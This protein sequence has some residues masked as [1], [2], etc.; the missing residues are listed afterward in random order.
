[1]EVLSSYIKK[2]DH[3]LKEI[4][5]RSL[6][7]LIEKLKLGWQLEDE[8]SCTRKLL[9]CLLAW[10]Q[11]QKPTL[12]SEALCLLLK[13][14]KTKSGTYIVKEM[15][16]NKILNDLKEIKNK[17][18]TEALVLYDDVVDT[19]YFLKTVESENDLVP[20]LIFGSSTSSESAQGINGDN[21]NSPHHED[22]TNQQD[23]FSLKYDRKADSSTMSTTS[24]GINVLLFPWVDICP[25]DLKT[26]VLLEDALKVVKSIRRCC[27]FICDVFLKDF[28]PEIF[29]N[30]PTIVNILV[31]IADGQQTGHPREALYVLLCITQALHQRLEQLFSIELVHTKNKV[32]VEV[33]ESYDEVNAEL[34][35]IAGG[36]NLH[37][38]EDSLTPLRQIPAP[39]FALNTAHSVLSIMS[40]SIVLLDPNENEV[41][42][43]RE[44]NTC[45]DL[46]DSLIQLLLKCVSEQF[47]IAEH[48]YKTH[49]DI[50]HKTCMLM[51]ML[52]DLLIKYRKS[53]MENTDRDHHRLAWLR[54]M[55]I[56]EKLLDWAKSSPIPPSSMIV[57]L[58]AAQLDPV[59]ELLYPD[60]S[61]RINDSLSN[62]KSVLD[63]EHKNKYKA[64]KDL[65][66]SMDFAVKFM[67]NKK[68]DRNLKEVLIEIQNSI[69]I[70]GLQH[71][72]VF[73]EDICNILLVKT[74]NLSDDNDWSVVRNI[75][76]KLMSHNIEWVK[77]KFYQK[78]EVMVNSILFSNEVYQSNEQCL[79]LLCDVGIL[80]EICCHGL[81]SNLEQVRSSASE[82]M[83]YLLRGRLVL[84]E[85][86][87]WRVLASL[88]PIL[89]L[90][91]VYAAHD[92]PIGKAIC[93]S[94]EPDIVERMGVSFAEMVSGL[95][96]LLF[97]KCVVVQLE[98]A[99]SLCR[100]LDDDRYLPPRE[101]LRSDLLLNALRRVEPEEF[102][103][104]SSSSFTKSPQTAGLVQ[105]LEVLKQDLRWEGVG[106][107]YVALTSRPSLEPSLRRSTLQ[108]LAVLLRQ[109]DTHD[110]FL[111]H[112]GVNLIVSLLRLSLMVEDYLVFPECAI[113]CVSVLNSVCFTSRHNLV[114]ITDLP[115]LLLRVILVFPS[116]ESCVLMSAQTLSL[117][118]WSGFVLQDID[119]SRQKV[120]ALPYCV[121]ERTSLPYHVNSYWNTSPNAEH[122]TLEW[123]LSEDEWRRCVRIRWWCTWAGGV[124]AVRT[125]L[126]AL[127]PLPAPAPSP[128]DLALMRS[129]CVLHSSTKGLLALENATSHAQVLEA[130]ALLQS[131]TSLVSSSST[132]LME[133][134]SLPWQH[135]RRFL[136]APPAS[137]NDTALLTALLRFIV[138][139]MDNVPSS[140][141]TMGWIIS[142]FICN[143][144]AVISLLS[145]DRLYPQQTSQEDIEVI[146]LHIHIVKVIWRC[147][148][149]LDIQDDYDAKRMESLLKILLSCLEN[150]DIKNFHMQGYLN[151][152]MRCIRYALYSRYCHLSEDTL[153]EAL[154]ILTK[155]F[156]NC[157][158]GSGFKSQGCKLDALLAL[159]AI[160]RQIYEN[161]VPVQ[162]WS[163][164][165][166][167]GALQAAAACVRGERAALRAAALHV[168]AALAHYTQL[169][170]H[171]LQCISSESI[172]HYALE[173]LLRCGE[174]NIVRAAAASLLAAVTAR[175]T[176][177]S[178]VFEND[179]IQHIKEADFL[180]SCLQIFIDF[181][182]EKK[183][184]NY[185]QPNMPLS[186]LE[187][188][189]EL[190]VRACKSGELRLSPSEEFVQAPPSVDLVVAVADV[191]HNISAFKHCPVD[192]WNEQGVYRVMFRCASWSCG[193]LEQRH[194]VRAAVCRALAAAAT[195]KCVRASLANT[196]DCLVNL[197]LTL[198]MT[199]EGDNEEMSARTQTFSLLAVLLPERSAGDVVW[200]EL[201]D[202]Q[203]MPFF[204]I[205][206]HSLQTDD[207]EL[208]DAAMH[209]LTQ[210]IKSASN[211][212]NAD[213]SS[214]EYFIEF[215]SNMKCESVV[216]SARSG[217]GDSGRDDC[218]PDYLCEELCKLLIYIFQDIFD[219][220]KCGASQ[221]DAWV[222]VSS[223]LCVLVSWCARCRAYGAHRQLPRAL[224]AALRAT[225]DHLTMHGKPA[226]VIR[227]A[228]HEPVLNTLYW[229]LTLI[230]SLM[231]DCPAAKE[232]FADNITCSLNK[233][234]PWCM[235]TEQLR[236]A[237]MHLL[238]TFTNDCPKA[239]ACM[240]ACVGG[241]NLVGEVC[242]V[243]GRGGGP[244]LPALRTLRHCAAHHHCR[245]ILLKSEVLS[246]MSKTCG[247]GASWSAACVAWARL[248]TALAR[249]SDGGAAL[250]SLPALRPPHPR[251]L[252]ALAHTAHHH[253]ATFLHAPDLL[254][255][256]SA[257][258]LT[259][260]TS[261]VVLAARAA[262]ALAANNHRAKLV[263]RGAG[264]TSAVQSALQRHQRSTAEDAQ[265]ALQLL[266][267]T[268]NVLQAT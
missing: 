30:R 84:S 40:R 175:Y 58:Q 59:I 3:P 26:I 49:K 122:C 195:R 21:Y 50:A 216:Q 141:A 24:D 149:L 105:M 76:L 25:S 162:R 249:Y 13:T 167:G 146:Q 266:T 154:N 72:E 41:L 20:P 164:A 47:W 206:M 83:Q 4:R 257:A 5:E 227:N 128:H 152:V 113:S 203:A 213:K 127:P 79:M 101:S 242:R 199:E 99:H 22:L 7:L 2:L 256:L 263:L 34:E 201:T 87:W 262:W 140:R 43:M 28:P 145:R 53:F 52:G 245:A 185:L 33:K 208:R 229:L 260:N 176:P 14:I 161:D 233:L 192:L 57:A 248:C 223:C 125:A 60:L 110:I 37:G 18:D 157:G 187:R 158:V 70:L 103:L 200:T 97:V 184:Q 138:T 150:I 61:R 163:E 94:L 217:A 169:L 54:L 78:L 210:L 238:V 183:Y 46:I 225:R 1:M 71:S 237:I 19:L 194:R 66:T 112:D 102:N 147:V 132:S 240:C 104:D 244:L 109:H 75:A 228:N 224:L 268:Y 235:M 243:V 126:A 81:S 9:E 230:N 85:S 74:N 239:W 130:L 264:V 114:K 65:Y 29:L 177:H 180:E 215:F 31:M 119:S 63:Q 86:C 42:S 32:S 67:K 108:Q 214:D 120:P 39:I 118:A 117:V 197:L 131:H 124:R 255:F 93:K 259:G 107:S 88:L 253:R 189:S 218:Q 261:E 15:G 160:L 98:A 144:V 148:R 129:S 36:G 6:Q 258:L 211:K 219:K 251:L 96:R 106:K 155:T 209:C 156:S 222:R 182:D 134:G 27:R 232:A 186:V 115:L 45:L 166:C 168:M 204:T 12:Q 135:V 121:T 142:Y 205:L 159:M 190:E 170:P 111:Q 265:Q 221:E 80:T 69:P 173:I 95:T 91:H 73:L 48:S 153:I 181:C 196:K 193:S 172:C 151:E 220:R 246:F 139:Y 241:R 234:W 133:Y 62:C 179:I 89:P 68:I 92:T 77:V 250:L 64:L 38:A 171:L 136:C 90:L 198:T 226:D 16:I 11:V 212:K 137:A 207:D 143:D 8:L 56:A 191:L 44:L 82:I 254:E 252:P 247:R 174:A 55:S 23:L 236:T 100:L 116:N 178:T 17:V 51:R 165:W 202:R 267:Y 123:L 35:K 10:F 188:R 231:V